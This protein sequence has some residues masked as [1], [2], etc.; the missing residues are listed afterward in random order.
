MHFSKSSLITTVI[1]LALSVAAQDYTCND[2]TA[3]NNVFGQ[4]GPLC[5]GKVIYDTFKLFLFDN[6]KNIRSING[7]NGKGNFLL[8]LFDKIIEDCINRR[9]EIITDTLA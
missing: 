4:Y 8:L 1:T 3:L 9:Q 2:G 5:D 6:I 7:I